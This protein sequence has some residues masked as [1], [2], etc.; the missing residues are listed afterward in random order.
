MPFHR[1]LLLRFY[2]VIVA[3]VIFRRYE[4]LCRLTVQLVFEHY[5][6]SNFSKV[7][8]RSKHNSSY[9]KGVPYIGFGPGSHSYYN[10]KRRW[11]KSDLSAYNRGDWS[12]VSDEELLKKDD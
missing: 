3:S 2:C 6:V 4:L 9:W 12:F 11:N 8:Q 10:G 1:L 7:G 5:E